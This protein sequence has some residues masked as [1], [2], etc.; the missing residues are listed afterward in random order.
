MIGL[1]SIGAAAMALTVL[2]GGAQAGDAAGL[3]SF[4]PRGAVIKMDV[5]YPVPPDQLFEAATG[6]ISGWWDHSFTSEPYSLEI[7]PEIGGYFL[8]R[9]DGEGNGAIH[10]TVSFVRRPERIQFKGPFGFAGRALDL[11]VTYDV[12]PAPEGS[13]L[14]LTV[15]M[16]GHVTPEED[17]IVEAV[18]R[19]FLIERLQTYLEAGCRGGGPC[20]A[21]QQAGH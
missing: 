1:R 7:Q 8:E 19:H 2:C 3:S 9:F 10:A 4:E 14:S 20:A 5:D 13:R 15:E 16:A 6:D 21:M 18:W 12:T 11:V 17:A